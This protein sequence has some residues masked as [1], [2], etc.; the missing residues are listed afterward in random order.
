MPLEE[1]LQNLPIHSR[2]SQHQTHARLAAFGV[3][4]QQA[5][6]RER[7]RLSIV[8]QFVATVPGRGFC[9]AAQ[10]EA[11]AGGHCHT[12]AAL[13]IWGSMPGCQRP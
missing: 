12:I 3:S 6:S 9:P 5:V 11:G 2:W 7:R 13:Q 1:L 4:V 8:R 10:R